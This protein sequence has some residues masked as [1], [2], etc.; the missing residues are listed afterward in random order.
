VNIF[1]DGFIAVDEAC[2]ELVKMP[3]VNSILARVTPGRLKNFATLF[4]HNFLSGGSITDSFL[5]ATGQFS[6]GSTRKIISLS[7]V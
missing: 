7:I 4:F 6:P 1:Y 3:G 5:W 2:N